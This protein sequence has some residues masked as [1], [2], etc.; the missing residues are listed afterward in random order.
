MQSL[1]GSE[2]SIKNI[3]RKALINLV[4]KSSDK[5]SGRYQAKMDGSSIGEKVSEKKR[6]MER[7]QRNESGKGAEMENRIKGLLRQ[8]RAHEIVYLIIFAKE[9][10]K[11]LRK[12]I[13]PTAL[14]EIEI[15]QK[16][17][18]D[19]GVNTDY[20]DKIK[21]MMIPPYAEGKLFKLYF[22][23]LDGEDVLN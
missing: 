8:A 21:E 20:L 22:S 5:R 17:W 15:R 4:V 12:F 16:K 11:I 9:I 23:Y 7:K 14:Q 19:R 18:A 3:K 6:E 10:Q 13:N 1:E 2:L